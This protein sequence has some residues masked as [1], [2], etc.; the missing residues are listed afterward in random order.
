MM[1]NDV[2]NEDRMARLEQRLDDLEKRETA[3]EKAMERSR[4]AMKSMVPPQTR[5]HMRAAGREQLLIFRSL[6]DHWVNRL[7][8]ESGKSEKGEGARENGRENI[9]ID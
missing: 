2:A 3:M 1:D 9:P 4:A 6:L 5:Q 7:G 8:E